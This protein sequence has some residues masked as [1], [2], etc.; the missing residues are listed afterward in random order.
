MA[1]LADGR[2]W[3]P[4]FLPRRRSPSE[5]ICHYFT[6]LQ[7]LYIKTAFWEFP[8]EFTPAGLCLRFLWKVLQDVLGPIAR[9]SYETVM[10][11]D[12][13][14]FICQCGNMYSKPT[15]LSRHQKSNCS[16]ASEVLRFKC[17]LCPYVAKRKDYLKEHLIR[18][19][20]L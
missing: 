1:A 14:R 6:I 16:A 2:F 8:P 12:G 18:H 11:K 20:C 4:V 9:E 3:S 10:M 13:V 17:N 15:N 19:H 5:F 7:Q